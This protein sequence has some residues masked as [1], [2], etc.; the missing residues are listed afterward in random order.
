MFARVSDL[1]VF[2]SSLVR[3]HTAPDKACNLVTSLY[4]G[5]IR[6]GFSHCPSK[7]AAENGTISKGVDIE[8]KAYTKSVSYEKTTRGS[9]LRSV[10]LNA[11]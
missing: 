5:H 9:A 4:F 11:A 2:H 3:K 6:V 10:G 8:C 1:L 7:V